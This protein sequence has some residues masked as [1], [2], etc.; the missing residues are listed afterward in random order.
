MRWREKISDNL[1][2]I[3]TGV[4]AG[5]KSN[6][7]EGWKDIEIRSYFTKYFQNDDS[8]EQD[9]IKKFSYI[10]QLFISFKN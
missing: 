8:Y 10:A 5:G 4:V 9:E 6:W 7:F 1:N 2:E 3:S